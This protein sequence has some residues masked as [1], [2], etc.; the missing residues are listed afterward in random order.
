MCELRGMSCV[1]N[2]GVGTW[3][4]GSR[5]SSSIGSSNS[6]GGGGS[7]ADGLAHSQLLLLLYQW[8]CSNGSRGAC[9]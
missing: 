8:R 5:R 3:L 7:S 4:Q 9:L 1:Q 2:A 6:S